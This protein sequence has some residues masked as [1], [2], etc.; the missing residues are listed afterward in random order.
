MD[1][2]AQFAI[3]QKCAAGK[4]DDSDTAEEDRLVRRCLAGLALCF[5]S[6]LYAALAPLSLRLYAD[7]PTAAV[8]AFAA[9]VCTYLSPWAVFLTV[10]MRASTV[11][12]CISCIGLSAAL[13][14]RLSPFNGMFV[15]LHGMAYAAG[16]FGYALAERRQHENAGAVVYIP[17]PPPFQSEEDL[18][19]ERL[20]TI[21]GAICSAVMSLACT[22]AGIWVAWRQGV[23][24]GLVVQELCILISLSLE[25]WIVTVTLHMPHGVFMVGTH[26]LAVFLGAGLLMLPELAVE[27]LFGQAVGAL[28]YPLFVMYLGGLLGYNLALYAMGM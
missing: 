12:G 7:R 2:S 11:F 1:T 3:T 10:T 25:M 17:S 21:G 16:L 5:L 20:A 28:V 8:W 18:D 15:A 4:P 14:A 9:I 26:M 6:V 19:R 27:F 23:F 22:A 13:I 24:E